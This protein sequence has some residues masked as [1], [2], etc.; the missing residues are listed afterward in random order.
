MLKLLE[1]AFLL[2][3]HLGLFLHLL[4][5]LLAVIESSPLLS[6]GFD[7]R[8]HVVVP[9]MVEYY[10]LG[11]AF[12]GLSL[13][14]GLEEG[15]GHGSSLRSGAREISCSIGLSVSVAAGFLSRGSER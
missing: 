2:S 14:E 5:V 1:H 9:G 13:N 10:S 4:V 7:L 12:M 8:E 6:L 3:L 11:K 15:I